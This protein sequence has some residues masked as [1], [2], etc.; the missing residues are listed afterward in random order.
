MYKLDEFI[1][2]DVPMIVGGGGGGLTRRCAVIS[3]NSVVDSESLG[4]GGPHALT[5]HSPMHHGTGT[6]DREDSLH[7]QGEQNTRALIKLAN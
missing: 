1:F 3:D 7:D 5:R 6:Y 4:G 2:V